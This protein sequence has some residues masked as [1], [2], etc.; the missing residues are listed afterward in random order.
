L[1]LQCDKI[2]I[3]DVIIVGATDIQ[4]KKAP[5]SNFGSVRFNKLALEPLQE[6]LIVWFPVC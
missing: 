5:F 6:N 3:P 4:D 1:Q 2:K